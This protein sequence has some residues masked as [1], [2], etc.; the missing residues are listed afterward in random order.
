MQV[1]GFQKSQKERQAGETTNL[2]DQHPKNC[3]A[4]KL[5]WSVAPPQ[6]NAR[7]K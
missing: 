3:R 7:I 2:G 5:N 1:P 6:T 4:T